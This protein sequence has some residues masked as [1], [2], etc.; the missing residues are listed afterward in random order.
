MQKPALDIVFHDEAIII[1]NKP[2]GLLSVPGKADDNKDCVAYRALE[3]FPDAMVVHRLDMSTSGLLIL[4]RGLVP[5]RRIS[6][7]FEDRKVSKKYLALLHGELEHDEGIINAPLIADWE[8][9]P[10]QKVDYEIGKPS[11]TKYRVLSRENNV[12]RV[13]FTPVTGRS[14]QLRVHS[15]HI[16]HPICGDKFYIGE[17]GFDRLKL[18]AT[19]I[20]FAHPMTGEKIFF[21][22]P[23]PF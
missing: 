11:L 12:S 23:A 20:H 8:N 16:G 10:R 9:R 14:H 13:E 21:E 3:Y 15:I 5:L 19:Y 6:R 2:S 7:Q 17:D 22:S 4:A 1:V 18:H